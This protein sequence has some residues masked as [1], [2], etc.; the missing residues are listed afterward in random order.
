MI[1]ICIC[2]DYSEILGARYRTDGKYSGEDFRETILEPKFQQAL[3]T[4]EKLTIDLDGG[5][6]NPVSFL[7]EAFGG[8][9]RKY[10][11][12][13]VLKLLEFISKDEPSQ[14]DRILDFIKHPSDNPVYIRALERL[15]KRKREQK[16]GGYTN[17]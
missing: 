14:I 7:E 13:E 11:S 16:R 8:L 2:Q 17:E 15:E 10:S 1:K 3:Q 4:G 9:A 6:G 5:Y 12:D